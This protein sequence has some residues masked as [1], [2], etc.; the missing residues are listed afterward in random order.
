MYSG[1]GRFL[2]MY[3]D[4]FLETFQ[5]F[6]HCACRVSD[7]WGPTRN[8]WTRKL[9]SFPANWRWTFST[10]VKASLRNPT[11]ASSP[12]LDTRVITAATESRNFKK[13][14]LFREEFRPT[15]KSG[16]LLPKLFWPAVR[17]NCSTF[18]VRGWR[19]RI[20]KNYEITW[21]IYSNSERSEQFLVTECFFNMFLI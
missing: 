3:W 14:I 13:G 12:M 10:T 8:L 16:I 2:K 7:K 20:F 17:K 11:P 15:V 21:T 1:Y 18:E 4:F 6:E 5:K 19:P 9:T